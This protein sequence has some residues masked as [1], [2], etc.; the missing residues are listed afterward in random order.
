MNSKFYR[1]GWCGHPVTKKG[2][3]LTGEKMLKSVYLLSLY[4]ERIKSKTVKISG[5]GCCDGIQE[6]EYRVN[7]W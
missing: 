4:K 1:C 5:K 2:I 3:I 6:S 7:E